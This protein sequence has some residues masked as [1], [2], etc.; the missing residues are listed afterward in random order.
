MLLQ[1][2]STDVDPD[3]DRHEG[4]DGRTSTKSTD[5]HPA[6]VK[7]DVIVGDDENFHASSPQHRPSM[8]DQATQ[9]QVTFV[10]R[11]PVHSTSADSQSSTRDHTA[12][13]LDIPVEV[14]SSDECSDIYAG[15]SDDEHD[16]TYVP[17]RKARR[18]YAS[19]CETDRETSDDD[20][21][22]E[23]D[24]ADDDGKPQQ[25]KGPVASRKY[26]VDGEQLDRLFDRCRT[27][28]GEVVSRTKKRARCPTKRR[29]NMCA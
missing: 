29:N 3:R 27:C 6:I 11:T 12:R 16:L 14:E 25:A 26:L 17:S 1:S 21:D 8:K 24:D 2:S 15:E 28:G 10:E 4:E 23:D 20:E 19:D 7:V 5:V 22:G 13:L 9:T 18:T